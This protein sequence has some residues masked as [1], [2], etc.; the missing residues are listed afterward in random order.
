MNPTLSPVTIAVLTYQ[1]EHLLEQLIAALY[2]QADSVSHDVSLL[3]VDNSPAATAQLFVQ[4]LLRSGDRYV[5][6]PRPGIS[7]GRNRCLDEATDGLLVFVD[8]D[9]VPEPR[10]LQELVGSWQRHRSAAVTGPV[11]PVFDQEPSAFVRAGRFFD[12]EP[13]KDGQ[14]VRAAATNNLLL[15]MRVVRGEGVRFPDQFGVTG[16]SDTVFTKQLIKRG[17]RVVWCAGAV[18]R[19]RIPVER[20]TTEWVL[21]RSF[22]VGNAVA[23]SMQFFAP[24][25][26]V[27]PRCQ[28]TAMGAAR[29]VAGVG[30]SAFGV[31]VGSI[32]H[33]ARGV[34][35][36][37][38][39]AGM[40]AGAVGL[41]YHE[42]DR[43]SA[44]RLK[45]AFGVASALL[46]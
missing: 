14:V 21:R 3:V 39:G 45:S 22:R 16:G 40:V 35:T 42:Y 1:R 24:S 37:M 11:V 9:E 10:W 30:R 27:V 15:N 20:T 46:K 25:G 7:A 23:R 5:H 19:E 2:D 12:P 4:P 43:G 32:T 28:A 44:S 33:Q 34:R 26:S 38:R 36:V 41:T 31:V 29:V 13:F 17:H 6:E 8:D 18:V